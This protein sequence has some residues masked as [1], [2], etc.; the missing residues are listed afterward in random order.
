MLKKSVSE[1][2]EQ[3]IGNREQFR[4]SATA[5]FFD[6][7]SQNSTILRQQHPKLRYFYGSVRNQDL[8]RLKYLSVN[9]F[10]FN[11]QTIINT[12]RFKPSLTIDN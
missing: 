10:I 2:R 7:Q 8:K 11:Q 4:L 6:D 1:G 3:G 12:Q 5:N 9:A